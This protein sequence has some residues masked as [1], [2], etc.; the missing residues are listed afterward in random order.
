MR[1]AQLT[2]KAAPIQRTFAFV[3]RTNRAVALMV[4]MEYLPRPI[5]NDEVEQTK[6]RILADPRFINVADMEQR[7]EAENELHYKILASR[8]RNITAD[9]GKSPVTVR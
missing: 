8:V 3:S 6:V 1:L 7:E 9:D 5:Y 2:K 4:T